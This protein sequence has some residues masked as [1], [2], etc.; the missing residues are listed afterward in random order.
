MIIR[1]VSASGTKRT[2]LDNNS[3]FEDLKIKI[4]ELFKIPVNK[5]IISKYPLHN[6]YFL[7]GNK[8]L[9]RYI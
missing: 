3:S 9:K 2:I 5:Q 8:S 4:E 1:I 7:K 6:P